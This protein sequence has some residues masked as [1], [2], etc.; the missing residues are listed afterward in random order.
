MSTTTSSLKLI[1]I[2]I[3]SAVFRNNIVTDGLLFPQ[4]TVMQVS[5]I[6]LLLGVKKILTIRLS[7][8]ITSKIVAAVSWPIVDPDRKAFV[9]V[10]FQFNYNMPFTPSSFYDPMYWRSLGRSTKDELSVDTKAGNAT[11]I[12]ER[13]NDVKNVTKRYVA[14]L[15][16][17]D[18]TKYHSALDNQ[19]DISAGE[20]YRS[21]ET[22]LVE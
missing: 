19:L 6:S 3:L 2:F 11:E 18:R 15:D 5:F 10:G 1:F 14:D 16:T 17:Y 21:V 22:M 7:L 13:D 20:L 12:H 9:N 4:Y 8:L